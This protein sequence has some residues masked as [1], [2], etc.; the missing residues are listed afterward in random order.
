[1]GAALQPESD[2]RL[3]VAVSRPKNV[4][5]DGVLLF[6]IVTNADGTARAVQNWDEP[7]T[8]TFE[9]L[10]NISSGASARVMLPCGIRFGLW[11][12]E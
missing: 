12:G 9:S 11:L 3:E 2:H 10:T 8:M 1:M 4:H 6:A 7:V 5:E